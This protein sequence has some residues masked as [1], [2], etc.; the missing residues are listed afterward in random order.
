MTQKDGKRFLL[1]LSAVFE[2]IVNVLDQFEGI[3]EILV[4]DK[5]VLF[6][7]EGSEE[8]QPKI[9]KAL[10]MNEVPVMGLEIAKVDLQKEYIETL[11]NINKK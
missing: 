2:D 1:K 4:K 5:D 8:D 11:N 7:Y 9:L 3:S 6:T 10:I